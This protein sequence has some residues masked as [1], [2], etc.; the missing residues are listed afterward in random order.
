MLC[1]DLFWSILFYFILLQGDLEGA[2]RCYLEA[3]RIK[4]DF[5]IG[6]NNVAG[7]FKDE[8]QTDIAVAYYQ[9]AIRICPLFADSYSNL[10]CVLRES[11]RQDEAMIAYETAIKLRPDFAIAHANIGACHYDDGNIS[12]AIASFK[13]AIQL[14][15][16][17]PDC[18][19]SS[20]L[21]YFHV[22]SALTLYVLIEANY[23]IVYCIVHIV[24]I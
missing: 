8:G 3:I 22:F 18:L 5:A 19:V 21:F 16:N 17:F 2:K 12:K 7:V 9:E 13:H 1:S 10:G 4:P 14:E 15:P 11:N 24:Y 23:V 6:W 20:L